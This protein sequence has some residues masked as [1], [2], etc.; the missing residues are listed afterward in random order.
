MSRSL[1]IDAVKAIAS[2]VIVLHH[3]VLYAPMSDALAAAWPRVVA[4]FADEGRLAVQPFLVI[5]G[6]L[7]AL[8]LQRHA[9]RPALAS[10]GQRY[11]R[12]APP[13]AL[14]LLLVMSVTVLV[15]RHLA[16]VDWL[17]PLPTLWALLVHLL[18]LQDVL[19]VPSLS[20][21]LWY[22]AIDFQLFAMFVLLARA[23]AGPD[24]SPAASL[25]PPAVALGTVAAILVFN[26]RPALDVWAI[27][28]LPAYGLGALA[29][30]SRASGRAR[31]CW[32]AT[33]AVLVLD[34][35]FEPRAR[36]LLALGTAVALV[37]A[38]HRAW[39]V[40]RSAVQRMV[41]HLGA[42]SYNVF[43]CHFAVIVLV[44]GLWVASGAQGLWPALLFSTLAWALSIALGTL[45]QRLVDRWVP[46][47]PARG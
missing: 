11:L 28:F 16:H 31:L 7:T 15:G 46:A 35:A 44:S 2:Q 8:A 26:H 33:V 1:P 12:L 9:A 23:L 36:P 22:V 41:Q 42:V 40:A 5:G 30:W 10:I 27:Y 3:L 25:L 32:W 17:S 47:A 18:F 39:P 19:G 21:G 43:L 29:A 14:A 6:W 20:A 13:L 4:F 38:S 45:V 34:W 37:A 24:R